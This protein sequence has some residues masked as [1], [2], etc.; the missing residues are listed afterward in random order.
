[1][2]FLAL[3][4]ACDRENVQYQLSEPF[5]GSLDASVCSALI[6]DYP[7]FWEKKRKEKKNSLLRD[8]AWRL[9]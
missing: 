9:P 4:I 8:L 6:L 5:P 7:V 3:Y 1:M 2:P